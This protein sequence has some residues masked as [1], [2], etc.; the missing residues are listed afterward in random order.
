MPAGTTWTSAEDTKLKS[1]VAKHGENDWAAVSKAVGGGRTGPACQGRWMTALKENLTRGGWTD[2]EDAY[3][4]K[5]Y[6]GEGK[7]KFGSW[8][9]RAIEL[10]RKFHNGVRRGGAETCNRWTKLTKDSKKEK[11]KSAKSAS[12]DQKAAKSAAKSATKK[13]LN[14]K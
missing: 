6:E 7:G 2:E 14:K 10:G 5:I 8:S 12:N 13:K 1:A 3:L 9:T 11:S 4:L